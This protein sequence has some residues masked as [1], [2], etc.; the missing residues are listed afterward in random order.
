M[1]YYLAVDIGASSGRHILGWLDHGKLRIEEVYRF[2]NEMK[3]INHHLCWDIDYLFQQILEGLK[4]CKKIHKIPKSMGIDTWAVDF[5]L[6]D[7]KNHRIG[8][9][10]A[11]RDAR[12]KNMD[13]KVYSVISKDQLYQRTGIQRQEFNTVFQLLAVHDSLKVADCFLMIPDYFNYLLTGKKMNEYTNATTTQLVNVHTHTWDERVLDMLEI[14]KHIFSVLEM[15]GTSAGYL[16]EEIIKEVGFD[17]EV[18]LVASH[19]TASAVMAIPSTDENSLYISSG[20]WSLLGTELKEANVSIISEKYN[21]TNEGGYAH[22]YRYLKNI[23]GLWMI[24][25]LKKE[26]AYDL[27]FNEISELAKKESIS[28]IVNCNDNRFLAPVSMHE[29]ICK[30]LKLS[31]QQ[32]PTSIGQYARVVYQSLA[33]SYEKGIREM[34]EV[35]NHHFDSIYVVGGGSNASY[36][37]ECIANQTHRIVYAGVS[38]ATAVGNIGAQMLSDH[39]IYDLISFRNIVKTSFLIKRIEGE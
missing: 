23:M 16:K 14:P 10:V 12:T 37:N 33:L 21:F 17:V 4:Q 1:D 5:V 6:L 35:T 7:K 11:Y 25:C 8:D 22:R 18:K 9:C 38:E 34:E 30:A 15:P 26:L 39:V 3:M 2:S 36:L 24:Q 29:E 28:S 32:V 19:D 27:S 20:T 13:Q 31:N